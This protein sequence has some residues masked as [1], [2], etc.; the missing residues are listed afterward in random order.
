MKERIR[1]SAKGVIG[2]EESEESEGVTLEIDCPEAPTTIDDPAD[3]TTTEC[4]EPLIV[5]GTFD[6]NT[7]SS[8]EIFVD[9]NS[10]GF[11][12][13][14]GDT[15]TFTIP[16]EFLGEGTH[17]IVAEASTGGSEP[18]TSESAPISITAECPPPPD[19]GGGGTGGGGGAAAAAEPV[20]AAVEPEAAVELEAAAE[21]AVELEVAQ[22]QV[23][24]LQTCRD[25]SSEYLT[26][27]LNASNP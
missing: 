3:G 26:Q 9:G 24:Q 13:L 4:E 14:D 16:A 20:A 1:L 12:E 2:T 25:P 8:V 18:D 6:S 19:G 27:R 23:A 7:F 15:W 10:A 11:A 21:V 22:Q 17:T 5:S